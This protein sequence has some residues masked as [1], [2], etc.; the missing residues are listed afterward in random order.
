MGL[1]SCSWSVY[2]VAWMS[3]PFDSDTTQDQVD[4]AQDYCDLNEN[5]EIEG[6]IWDN[7]C[8]D[9]GIRWSVA[10]KLGFSVCL[11]YTVA[12]IALIIG[13]WNLASR[14]VGSCL[15]CMAQCLNFGAIISIGVFRFNPL[16]V[17]ASMS[18]APSKYDG[19]SFTYLDEI[20]D[21]DEFLSDSRTY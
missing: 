8:I 20:D 3:G 1:P 9:K 10:Y 4:N 16:G 18:K 21:F 11:I 13:A 2:D 5:G 14:M 7:D 19:G 12:L 17:L 6:E 15:F